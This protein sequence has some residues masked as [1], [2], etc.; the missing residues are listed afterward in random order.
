MPLQTTLWN[1]WLRQPQSLLFRK[2]FFQVHLWAG[3][4]CGLYVLVISVSGSAVVYRRELTRIFSREPAIVAGSGPRMTAAQLTQSASAKYPGYRITHVYEARDPT[5]PVEIQLQGRGK[6]LQ[7]LFNPFTGADLGNSLS[8]GFRC[9]LWFVDLHDNLLLGTAGRTM[10]GIGGIMTIVLGVTG[11]V[12]W[13]PGTRNWRRSLSFRWKKNRRGSMWT[14]HNAFGFWF[15]LFVLM[16]G[17]SGIYLSFPQPFEIVAE[18]INSIG[19]SIGWV[20]RHKI[21][22]G[23][24][25]LFWLARLHFGRFS[26]LTVKLIWTVL[27]LVPAVLFITGT[28][29]WWNRV[30]RPKM[31]RM[32][33]EEAVNAKGDDS[34]S[35]L[36][37]AGQRARMLP[38]K[39]SS[40]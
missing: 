7:R 32:K 15:L 29:M 25:A 21:L 13:W 33:I 24:S 37:A 23:D 31:Q 12:I 9:T 19:G 6:A 39:S 38:R 5:K 40:T 18:R 1:R 2:A 35:L 17:F 34:W 27:G 26:T 30:L 8:F 4:A 10:N 36:K 28:V 3:I 22:I 14:L 16:W 20:H 11:M